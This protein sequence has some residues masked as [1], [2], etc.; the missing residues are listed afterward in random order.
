MAKI[1]IVSQYFWPEDFRINDL[2]QIL[3]AHD[4]KITVLTGQ[5]NYPQGQCFT[6]YSWWKFSSEKYGQAHVIRVP[7]VPRNKGRAL[8]LILNYLSFIFFSF[9]LLPYLLTQKF[10]YVIGWGTSPFF[11]STTGLVL[12]KLKKIP[13]YVWILDLW[14][15]SLSATGTIQN[16]KALNFILVFVRLFYTHCTKILCISQS[17][18]S[19][20]HEQGIHPKK[21]FYF[22]NWAENTYQ[23]QNMIHPK[24]LSP[25]FVIPSGTIF[26]YAGNIGEAQDIECLIQAMHLCKNDKTI[27]FLILGEGRKK[28]F[29]EKQIIELQLSSNV[30]ILGHFPQQDMPYFFN[31][32]DA[33]I[34]TLK[35]EDIFAKTLPGRVMSFMAAGKP[36]IAAAGHEIDSVLKKSHAGLSSQAGN[37]QLLAQNIKYFCGLESVEKQ[38]M[39]SQSK[40][41]FE[42]NFNRQNVYQNLMKILNS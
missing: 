36:I 1:L 40:L 30:H 2:T 8:N 19:H 4:H 16:K 28:E 3:S 22:P 37:A 21:L 9:L 25:N 14:P 24:T 15:E 10:D 17:F 12:A 27:H 32:T 35:N 5:P 13:F 18:I 20:I 26:T 41:Y 31:H 33:F 6:G 23:R 42:Q 11:Q 38:K 39:G 29:L 7:L 34:V